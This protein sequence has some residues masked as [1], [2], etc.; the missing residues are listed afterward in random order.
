[1]TIDALTALKSL[2]LFRS[3]PPE[4]L[5]GLARNCF[6][7]EVPAGR[8]L[9]PQGLVPDTLFG[10]LAGAVELVAEDGQDCDT[11]SVVTPGQVFTLA[12]V[13]DSAIALTMALHC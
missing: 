5:P 3:V 6:V 13:L 4:Q 12:A 10:L 9:Q 1:M 2:P 11:V 8:M 7:M